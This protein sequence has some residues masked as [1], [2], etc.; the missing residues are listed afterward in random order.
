[1]RRRISSGYQVLIAGDDAPVADRRNGAGAQR[2]AVGVDDEPRDMAEH[3]RR[4]EPKRQSARHVGGTDIPADML[5][6]RIGTD[7]QAA[8]VAQ[9]CVCR[10]GRRPAAPGHGRWH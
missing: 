7:A 4:I 10:H 9:E 6:Q 3:G 8:E 2:A 5:R 1:M